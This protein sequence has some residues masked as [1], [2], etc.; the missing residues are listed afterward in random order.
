MGT[1]NPNQSLAEQITK[2]LLKKKLVDTPSEKNIL[3]G[4]SEG[5]IRESE[6]K[7]FLEEVINQ[8]AK[9]SDE[10]K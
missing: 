3:K 5:T 10:N 6:W 1:K 8:P 9:S 7:V 4:I 2:E